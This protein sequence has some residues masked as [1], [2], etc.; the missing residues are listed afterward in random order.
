MV[1]SMSITFAVVNIVESDKD[2]RYAITWDGSRGGGPTPTLSIV[3]IAT[4]S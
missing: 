3:T 1:G 4:H 2:A